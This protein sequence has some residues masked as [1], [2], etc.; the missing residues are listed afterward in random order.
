MS[1]RARA[2][3]VIAAVAAALLA[4][5]S[6][7]RVAY[8]A[9][10]VLVEA[11]TPET[12]GPIARLRPDPAFETVA[13]ESSTG[14]IEAALLRPAGDGP[15]AAIVLSHG[16]DEGGRR[17]PRLM[18]IA[19][20]LARAGFVS[21]V[22]EYPSLK[23]LTVRTSAVDEIVD[24]YRYLESLPDVDSGRV[25]MFGVSYAGGLSVLAA[26]DPAIADRVRFVFSLGGYCDLRRVVVYM[27]TGW[28]REDGRW[29]YLEPENY[30]R[31]VFLANSV[32][33]IS[34]PADRLVLSRIARE[35][36]RDPRRDVSPLVAELGE[37]GRDAYALL[38]SDDPREAG[39]IIDGLG[40]DVR[41]YFDD[42]SPRGS[43]D[44]LDARLILAHGRDDN[45]IPYPE[46]VALASRAD[47]AAGVRLVLVDSFRHVDLTLGQS[48]GRGRIA[49][50]GEALRLLGLTY[51]LVSQGHL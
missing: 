19:D 46:S 5:Q 44:R 35:K 26:C 33:L 22:P 24:A 25:G 7:I 49:E 47:P 29:T 27:M 41:A 23:S 14:T 4:T 16:M 48:P 9:T 38:T 31:W 39:A 2:I 42:L 28:Y 30:G 50:V 15:H 12:D 11:M 40:G 1:R 20:A 13:F 43:L 18:N 10:L 21:L 17:D 45:M 6:R 3:I 32:H 37:E 34:D 36:L 51:D 8:L